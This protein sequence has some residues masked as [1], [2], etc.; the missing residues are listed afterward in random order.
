MNSQSTGYRKLWWAIEGVLAG[1]GMPYVALERRMNHGGPLEAYED[2]LPLL[3]Q[4]GIRAAVCLLNIPS[5]A[6]VFQSAGFE[7]RCW[8]IGDGQ[9]P[10]FAQA[11]AFVDFVTEC[12]GRKVPVAVFCE[13]G[14]GR[15]G[16]MI[17]A[18][19]IQEGNSAAQAI[20]LAR[21]KEPSAVETRSQI[22]FLEEFERQ[23]AASAGDRRSP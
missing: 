6:A 4:E 10:D 8:P 15:T 13:A 22:L 23:T 1:M 11:R 5:D 9:P 14:L 17:A 19:L 21:T 18:Y 2:D 16:T 12:R 7:F 3:C 20:A